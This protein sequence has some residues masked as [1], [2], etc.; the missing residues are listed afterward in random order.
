MSKVFIEESTLTS[1]GSAIREKTGKS[2]LIAPLN[3]ANE[4]KSIT[5]GGGGGG[6]ISEEMRTFTGDISY[7][8]QNGRFLDWQDTVPFILKDINRMGYLFNY[9]PANCDI[10]QIEINTL[11]YPDVNDGAYC[12]N[13]FSYSKNNSLPTI[14]GRIA[15][16][17]GNL[18][19]FCNYLT[20]DT[21]N[22]FFA[23]P[24]L[25]FAWSN[26]N[27]RY[28]NPGINGMFS[29]CYSLR[30]INDILLRIHQ[31]FRDNPITYTSNLTDAYSSAFY[32]CYL[33][34]EI[35]NIP[36]FEFPK[37]GANTSNI[38]SSTFGS[39]YR[40]KEITFM[41]NNGI[42]YK[43]QW[44]GQSIEFQYN[45]G[46]AAYPGNVSNYGISPDKEVK[47]DATYQALKND[48][49]WFTCKEEYSR[50][51]H[52]SAVNTINSLPDTSEYLATA[53][54]TNTIKFRGNCG[55]LTDGGAINTLTAEEIAVATAKGWTVSLF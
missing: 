3:M 4:I 17:G 43:K 16:L 8:F 10:S 7:L 51:N 35:R 5:T 15:I 33:L 27:S 30:N 50:Y 14:N 48:A 32:S 37:H 49:D 52:D 42:P 24:K 44:K 53:G 38:F 13:L 21:L 23:N 55:K 6:E 39:C 54:G 1:I 11:N 36:I 46:Y 40:A 26:S 19:G 45:I 31:Y 20:D 22:N 29:N 28:S 34:D 25:E 47:D 9:C 2:A 41:T 12:N 18:F